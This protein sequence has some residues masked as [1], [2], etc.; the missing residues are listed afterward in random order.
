MSKR[1]ASL[2]AVFALSLVATAALAKQPP[3]AGTLV[4]VGGALRYD[5]EEIWSRIVRHAAE[6]KTA[7]AKVEAA[8]GAYRPK[9]AIFPTASAD[10]E[11]AGRITAETLQTYGAD[12]FV[13][14]LSNK[15]A[16]DA[17]AAASDPALVEQVNAAD[18][19]YFTG[20]QQA[21]ITQ[22]LCTADGAK[23]PLL[24]AIWRVYERGG[25]V[26]GTSAGAAIMSHIMY[27][28]AKKILPTLQNGVTMGKEVDRGL[29]FLD[30]QWF[31]EQH[32]LVRG[33][34]ARALVAM[35]ANQIKYGVGVDENTAIVVKNDDM[36]VVGYRGAIVMDLSEAKE[37]PA[38]TRRR[39]YAP[40][41]HAGGRPLA[42]KTRRAEARSQIAGVSPDGERAAVLQRRAGQHDGAQPDVWADEQPAWRSG[43][44][45]VRRRGR[46]E[47]SRAGI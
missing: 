2:V 7:V 14:P 3:A 12:A 42:E 11:R 25:V 34:F 8:A 4:I 28:D 26:A 45:G 24:D 9:I 5:N 23:T 17:R 35:K 13:V 41:Q 22:A 1:T 31:V 6:A 37:D 38:V 21:R 15:L 19:I 10:P 47:R 32:T 40:H 39:R 16:P 30:S 43:R 36:Q 46:A 44:P 18:G 33:R 29:G 27:R 20:G